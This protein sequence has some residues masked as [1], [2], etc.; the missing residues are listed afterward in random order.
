MTLSV[1]IGERLG[2]SNPTNHKRLA[3]AVIDA[4]SYF[5]YSHHGCRPSVLGLGGGVICPE[6]KLKKH[7]AVSL[8]LT[9]TNS[10]SPALK[11]LAAC[12]IIKELKDGAKEM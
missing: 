2:R 7:R 11:R 8:W 12:F 4:I 6:R 10:Q 9:V 5:M 1:H 3:S